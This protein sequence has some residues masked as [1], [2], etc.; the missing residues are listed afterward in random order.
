MIWGS[1]VH[2]GI[3]GSN[4]EPQ[5]KNELASKGGRF[6]EGRGGCQARLV[7]RHRPRR[8]DT[9]GTP[10]PFVRRYFTRRPLKKPALVVFCL[11]LAVSPC[12]AVLT[13]PLFPGESLFT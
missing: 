1:K 5:G 11:T 2:M 6:G 7:S 12:S 4:N 9:K 8:R 10:P 13:S 3:E